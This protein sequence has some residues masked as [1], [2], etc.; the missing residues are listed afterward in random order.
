MTVF[1]VGDKVRV[2]ENGLS[3][4]NHETTSTAHEKLK[5]GAIGKITS[6][7]GG[8]QMMVDFGFDDRGHTPEEASEMSKTLANLGIFHVLLS[9]EIEKVD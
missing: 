4:Y 8:Y 2:N 9:D 5:N 1:K 3:L 7:D 6:I